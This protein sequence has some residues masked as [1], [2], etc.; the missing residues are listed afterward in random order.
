MAQSPDTP[1]ELLNNIAALVQNLFESG[2]AEGK[3][4]ALSSG[5]LDLAIKLLHSRDPIP[6]CTLPFLIPAHLVPIPLVVSG[7]SYLYNIAHELLAWK[8]IFM[9]RCECQN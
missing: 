6:V 2:D 8:I 9:Y 1:P 7:L 3:K 5:V 4:N